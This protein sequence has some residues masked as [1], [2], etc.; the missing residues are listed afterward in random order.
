MAKINF[1]QIS[2]INISP[3]SYR[4]GSV[5]LNAEQKVDSPEVFPPLQMIPHVW[6]MDE[7]GTAAAPAGK[8]LD[9]QIRAWFDLIDLGH[10]NSSLKNNLDH[11]VIWSIILSFQPHSPICRERP[12]C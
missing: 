7:A 3:T 1:L 6:N 4:H 11:H 12:N 10:E 2:L 9:D 8:L 5:F